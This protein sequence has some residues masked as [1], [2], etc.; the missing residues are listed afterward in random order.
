MTGW[1][2]GGGRRFLSRI[3]GDGDSLPCGRPLETGETG[4]RYRCRDK[5]DTLATDTPTDRWRCNALYCTAL[6]QYT[7]QLGAL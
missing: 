4:I 6:L 1:L 2:F 3:W 7:C 5:A